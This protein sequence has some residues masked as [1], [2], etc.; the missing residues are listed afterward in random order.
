MLLQRLPS[1]SDELFTPCV[2]SL[3]CTH[4][5]KMAVA[6]NNLLQRRPS[7][8]DE[9]FTP[10]V[11]SHAPAPRSPCRERALLV[12]PPSL[13]CSFRAK[14]ALD[15]RQS[16]SRKPACAWLPASAA[17]T[18]GV[19]AVLA[20]FIHSRP[21]FSVILMQSSA[22]RQGAV[23]S[24][25]QVACAVASVDQV[26]EVSSCM[27]SCISGAGASSQQLRAVSSC[28]NSCVSSCVQ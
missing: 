19:H 24:T 17:P 23:A 8:S 6:L 2:E 27:R 18:P 7:W 12:P 4:T 25:E 20:Q 10:C 11:E 21:R 13:V 22:C 15:S 9:L 5:L 16:L 28:V 1:W 26:H 3:A 14:V